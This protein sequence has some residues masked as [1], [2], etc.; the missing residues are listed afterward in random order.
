MFQGLEKTQSS[1]YAFPSSNKVTEVDEHYFNMIRG[2][3]IPAASKVVNTRTSDL[4]DQKTT[5]DHPGLVFS[6]HRVMWSDREP[7]LW[8]DVA[9]TKFVVGLRIRNIADA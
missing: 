3:W 7:E 5:S 8:L 2:E 4:N 9:N 6:Y 1:E